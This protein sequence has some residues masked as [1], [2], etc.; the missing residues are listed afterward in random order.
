MSMFYDVRLAFELKDTSKGL[1]V[2]ET[3]RQCLSMVLAF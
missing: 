1:Q 3:L 2:R